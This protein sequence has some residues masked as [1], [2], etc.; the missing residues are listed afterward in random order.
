MAWHVQP[1]SEYETLWGT[2]VIQC[3]GGG[4]FGSVWLAEDAVDGRQLAVKILHENVLH[5]KDFLEAFRRGVRAMSILSEAR[6]LNLR[7]QVMLDL[8]SKIL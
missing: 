3:L 7:Q 4:A 5:E 1:N 2:K 6:L 8:C